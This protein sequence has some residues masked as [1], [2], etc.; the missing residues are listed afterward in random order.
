MII[1]LTNIDS[2]NL[3]LYQSDIL[4]NKKLTNI[5]P[6]NM[7]EI[8]FDSDNFNKILNIVLEMIKKEA[9]LNF[10]VFV[11]N[12]WGYIQNSQENKVIDFNRNFKDQLS[13]SSDYSFV[14]IIKSSKTV[15]FFK[16]EK[17]ILN[18]SDLLIFRTEDFVKDEFDDQDRIILVGSIAQILNEVVPIKKV[19]I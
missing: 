10:D 17:I 16:E 5:S 2:E 15:L 4:L 19:M 13:I 6:S 3:Q 12:M 14:Y 8:L 9:N 7:Y 1:K 18:E 11:K